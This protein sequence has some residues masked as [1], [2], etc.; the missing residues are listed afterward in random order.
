MEKNHTNINEFEVYEVNQI[1]IRQHEE[2]KAKCSGGHLKDFMK[3]YKY[4][5]A[6]KGWYLFF[7]F[8]FASPM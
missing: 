6:E 1:F 7:T 4:D 5:C 8:A 3:G 2:G